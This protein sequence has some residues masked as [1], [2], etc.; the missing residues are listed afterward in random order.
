MYPWAPDR[1]GYVYP[2]DGLLPIFDAVPESE[3]RQPTQHNGRGG[4]AMPVIKNGLTTGTTIGWL[5]GLK[6][7]VRHYDFYDI[8][9]TSF[10]TTIVPYGGRGA[11][12]EGGD[13]GS[14]IL[15]RNGR[16]V[17]LLTSGGGL[18][19]ETDVTFA[20]AWYMLEPHIKETLKGVHLYR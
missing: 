6:S 3:M 19:D 2:Q 9:F 16:I 18:T 10:E 5:N 14:I 13:S 4:L 1:A 11:F 17:A 20:T 7:L 8:T 15:D 12:S